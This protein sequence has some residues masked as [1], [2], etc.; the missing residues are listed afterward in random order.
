MS[1]RGFANTDPAVL[2]EIASKGGKAV[3]AAGKAYRFTSEK[4]R[5]AGRKGGLALAA[6]RRR[7]TGETCG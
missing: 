3:H 6:K 7:K 4:A 5:E 1:K 2:S